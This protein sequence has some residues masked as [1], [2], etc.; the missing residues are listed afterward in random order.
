MNDEMHSRSADQNSVN[1]FLESV[2]SSL[3]A[4]VVVV[5]RDYRIKIW[6]QGAN[7]LWGVRRD[8]AIELN[9]LALDI[10]LPVAELRQPIR[11][12]LNDEKPGAWLTVP[13]VTRRGKPFECRVTVTPLHPFESLQTVGAIMVMEDAANPA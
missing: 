6:N 4:A 3:P 5:D 2:F 7:E 9:F 10:G 1:A 13:A 8:E 11:E 12:V